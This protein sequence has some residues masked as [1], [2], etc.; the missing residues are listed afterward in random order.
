MSSP[1]TL[2]PGQ[3]EI[4]QFLPFALHLFVSLA[5]IPIA[6]PINRNKSTPAAPLDYGTNIIK[7][8]AQFTITGYFWH[9]AHAIPPIVISF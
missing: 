6:E 8:P 2:Q 5:I 1:C 9:N 3:I 4:F 7:P